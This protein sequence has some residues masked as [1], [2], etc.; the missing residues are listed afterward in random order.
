MEILRYERN[1]ALDDS[2]DVLVAGGGPAG[3]AAA[4]AA[5]RGG[6]KTLLIER[7]GA[8]GGMGTVGRIPGFAISSDGKTRVTAGLAASIIDE[9][10]SEMPHIPATRYDW[11]SID[12]EVLKRV[13]D[14]RA[15]EAGAH[16]RF[17][18]EL[19][20]AVSSQSPD[21][22]PR[23]RAA[24]VVLFNKAGLSAVRAKYYIDCTGDAD[25]A[26]FAG[27]EFEKGDERTGELQP[28]TM[29]F[30]LA[31]V[32]AARFFAWRD[33]LPD[34][35]RTRD[36]IAK[37]KEAGDLDIPEGQITSYGY[38]SSS[39]IGLNFSHQYDVDGTDP[40]QVSRAEIEGRQTAKQLADFMRKY[41]A[42]C[43]NSF[44]AA[45]GTSGIRETRRVVGEYRLGVEDYDA[46]RSFPDEILRNSNYMDVHWNSKTRQ[47]DYAAGKFDWKTDCRPYVSGE[48]HGIPFRSLVPRNLTNVLV[49][50][51]S[52][53]AD[54]PLQGACRTMP[55]C[56]GTG[57]AAGTA[58]ALAVAAELADIRQVDI[59]AV[60]AKLREHGAYLPLR[61]EC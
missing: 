13:Y 7:Q 18:T 29:C 27:A 26:V 43:E 38:V 36:A 9:M 53:S 6:A 61:Q 32:D 41:C 46:R 59:Q 60:R 10:K 30:L 37:A 57:E 15:A 39:A 11:V 21:G 42:G 1:V 44:L 50:G 56:L 22:L 55:T 28:V 24:H 16:V 23:N 35:Q 20:D 45:T 48:S 4:I 40:E 52:L 5:A 2:W 58:A 19:V 51:R 8:L 54:R 14:R 31:G 49:A 25:L 33:E 17:H 47:A 34:R 3:C 12:A